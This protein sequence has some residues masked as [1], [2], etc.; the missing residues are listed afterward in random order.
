MSSSTAPR[1][2]SPAPLSRPSS[3]PDRPASQPS[4]AP[5]ARASLPATARQTPTGGSLR[6]AARQC[7]QHRLML[8]PDGTCILCDREGGP[9]ASDV[10]GLHI[11]KLRPPRFLVGCRNAA[12]GDERR[13]ALVGSP[14]G[15]SRAARR[16]A[17]RRAAARIRPTGS[18][19]AGP[20]PGGG[21]GS[22]ARAQPA[23]RCPA[24][25]AGRRP[26]PPSD[27]VRRA[28]LD[29]S[30]PAVTQP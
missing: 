12:V 6:P 9:Y 26:D 25:G 11:K 8:R 29:R 5:R 13:R 28:L 4:L 15:K 1:R 10:S 30:Q 7:R 23:T 20:C 14:V 21:I 22:R 17:A 24:P 19:A 18:S 3:S 16:A 27:R 2:R